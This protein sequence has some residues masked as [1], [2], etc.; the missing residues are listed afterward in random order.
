MILQLVQYEHMRTAVLNTAKQALRSRKAAVIFECSQGRHRSVGATGILYQLLRPLVS[1]I[2][3]IHASRNNWSSTCGGSCPECIRGPP[4]QFHNEVDSL[5]RELLAQI[6]RDYIE[7]CTFAFSNCPQFLLYKSI[8]GQVDGFR[9]QADQQLLDSFVHPLPSQPL[10]PSF[11]IGSLLSVDCRDCISGGII[12]R[13]AE[14]CTKSTFIFDSRN[15][16]LQK[17]QHSKN[18]SQKLH[19]TVCGQT[20]SLP[21]I[22]CTA[23]SAIPSPT[24]HSSSSIV[25]KY[26]EQPRK[27]DDEEP[28][29]DLS[30]RL[31]FT[32]ILCSPAILT[33]KNRR[34]ILF[35]LIWWSITWGERI[36]A[37]DDAQSNYLHQGH[38]TNGLHK[39][40]DVTFQVGNPCLD[41]L[42]ST[43]QGGIQQNYDAQNSTCAKIASIAKITNNCN[44]ALTA[45]RTCDE[46]GIGNGRQTMR[47]LLLHS[48]LGVLRVDCTV[49]TSSVW[50]IRMA[51][52]VDMQVILEHDEQP[53][54]L[55]QGFASC[56]LYKLPTLILKTHCRCLHTIRNTFSDGRQQSCNAKNLTCT[57]NHSNT[58]TANSFSFTMVAASK[59]P[60][61]RPAGTRSGQRRPNESFSEQIERITKAKMA[62]RDAPIATSAKAVPKTPPKSAGNVAPTTP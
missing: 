58:K 34:V 1:K 60:A 26:P 54:C 3:V 35:L 55:D 9:C 4:P 39:Y 61:Y 43:F 19:N 29:D 51:G 41:A 38:A 17:S 57:K 25:H 31:L 45:A 20:D 30:W 27:R 48:A 5:R 6:D 44:P 13:T 15:C 11:R 7:P 53:E 42:Q 16:S 32:Y 24:C 10:V 21:K 22:E 14:D 36:I 28:R 23:D 33:S 8:V 2:T 49:A 52:V 12:L 46:P 47:R 50:W 18:P 40:S 62:S 59:L 37:E 56:G